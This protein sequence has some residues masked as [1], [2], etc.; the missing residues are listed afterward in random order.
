MIPLRSVK[1]VHKVVRPPPN[2]KNCKYNLVHVDK[3]SGE[4]SSVCK[5]FRVIA[6]QEKSIYYADTEFVRND[7]TLCGP[8]G[9]YFKSKN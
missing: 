2:C 4:I 8:M 3:H 9:T 1:F 7:I 5:L 6:T